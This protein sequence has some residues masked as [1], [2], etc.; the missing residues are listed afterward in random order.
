[1]YLG[2]AALGA[3]GYYMYKAGG[4]PQTAKRDIKRECVVGLLAYSAFWYS[5]KDVNQKQLTPTRL[6][7]KSPKANEQRN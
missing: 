2:V 1:M 7:A 5:G 3:G 6:A 4:D